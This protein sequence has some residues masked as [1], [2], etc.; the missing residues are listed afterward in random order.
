M[1]TW[2]HPRWL[3]SRRWVQLASFIFANSLFLSRWK[4]FCY[5]VL[6]CWSCP[7]ANFSCPIG[8]LQNSSSGA[9]LG[10]AGGKA[11]WAIVPLFVLGTLFFFSSTIGRMTC[12]WLCPT[13]WLQELLGRRGFGH[14]TPR[15]SWYFRYFVLVILVFVVPY[16]TSEAW[17]SK[18][19]P[20]GALEGGIP[21]PLL[22]PE[23]QSQ[24]GLMWYLKMAILAAA[25]VAALVWRRPFCNVVC[26]LGAILSLMN[27]YSAWRIDYNRRKCTDCMWCVKSCPQGIDPRR[28][29]NGHAC[30]G[31]LECEKCPFGAI[32][33]RAMWAHTPVEPPEL[34]HA[35]A[36]REAEAGQLHPE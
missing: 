9:R 33:S 8:A 3:D 28:D 22:R 7:T 18:L 23:L 27:R 1:A 32:H 36:Q 4:G 5:P 31:C 6:N 34:E 17:F 12:G 16:Y 14:R 19:C 26:P 24:I 35:Q 2:R 21:Q 30:I 20:M 25:I 11:W 15:W 13:G 10:I 29:V